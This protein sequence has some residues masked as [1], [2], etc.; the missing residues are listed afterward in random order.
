MHPNRSYT[1]AQRSNFPVSCH[2]TVCLTT[3]P[4]LNKYSIKL[5]SQDVVKM[6]F[7]E[8]TLFII[9]FF[10]SLHS[11]LNNQVSLTGAGWEQASAEKNILRKL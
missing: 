5:E 11:F 7:N 9:L 8:H 1:Q 10:I 2:V 3:K 6:S 4:W